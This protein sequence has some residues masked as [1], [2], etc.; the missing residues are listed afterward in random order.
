MFS[1]ENF[2]A[3]K[4]FLIFQSPNVFFLQRFDPAKCALVYP[5]EILLMSSCNVHLLQ[6]IKKFH[7]I[8]IEENLKLVRA[9]SFF[10]LLIVNCFGHD[11]SFNTI[12]PI[13]SK[14]AELHKSP[15]TTTK[16]EVMRFFGFMNFYTKFIENIYIKMKP[17]YSLL[18]Y[19]NNFFWNK[20]W[21]LVSA[22]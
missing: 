11:F 10:M 2:T 12:K 13:Q 9:K 21:E 7:D 16:S 19:N 5:Y 4:V 6:L 14:K 18:H 20:N 8:A 17:L 15:S 3:L 22:N 1:L